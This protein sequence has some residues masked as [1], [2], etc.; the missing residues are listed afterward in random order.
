VIA[1]LLAIGLGWFVLAIK[2]LGHNRAGVRH[3]VDVAAL[4]SAGCVADAARRAT[5]VSSAWVE[6]V[7]P[8]VSWRLRWFRVLRDETPGFELVHFEADGDHYEIALRRDV[9][10]PTQ[11]FQIDSTL[12]GPGDQSA[13]FQDARVERIRATMSAA[14][15]EIAAGCGPMP[16]ASA[17]REVL[18]GK[19]LA[20][21][22]NVVGAR[23][24]P[25]GSSAGSR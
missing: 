25:S 13:Q 14:Y 15:A 2:L 19:K 7:A 8:R 21:R 24:A 20:A 1:L 4:P 17:V 11:R 6:H 16:P 23:I 3:E 9:T 22:G 18:V 12:Y 10:A 5:G